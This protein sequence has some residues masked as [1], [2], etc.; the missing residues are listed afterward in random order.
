M[1]AED[2]EDSVFTRNSKT[3]QTLKNKTERLELKHELN[4]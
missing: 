1:M 4:R 2:G 3:P